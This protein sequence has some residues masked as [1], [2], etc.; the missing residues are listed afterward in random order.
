M[1]PSQAIGNVLAVHNDALTVLH[2]RESSDDLLGFWIAAIRSGSAVT[3]RRMRIETSL[4][5]MTCPSGRPSSRGPTPRR[6]WWL[7]YAGVGAD[8]RHL[9]TDDATRDDH[10]A[11]CAIP[12]ESPDAP[13][14]KLTRH[15]IHAALFPEVGSAPVR[16]GRFELLR[17][18]GQGG[19]GE[20]YVAYDDQLDREVALKLLLRERADDPSARERM[21]REAQVLARLSHPNVVQIHEAGIHDD[22]VYLVMELVDGVT[23]R[24]W[25]DDTPEGSAV[26]P[27]AE[28]LP[29]MIAAGQ[30]LA[31]AHAAGL[32][33]RDFKPDNV[34]VGHDGRVRVLD[35]GLARPGAEQDEGD[36]S[37]LAISA[38]D[39]TTSGSGS[40]AGR[41]YGS[42]SRRG[43]AQLTKPGRV[44]G[45]LAYMSPEQ[46]AARPLDART[47]QFSFC[48][49]LYEALY[50][51]RPF[52]G[53]TFAAHLMAVTHGILE[54]PEGRA[55]IP[56]W[57]RALVLRGLA[58][59]PDDRHPDMEALLRQLQRPRGRMG[60]MGLAAGVLVLGGAGLAMAL[61]PPHIP[62]AQADAELGERW[63]DQARERVRSAFVAAEPSYGAD[64]AER[65][66]AALDGR[67]DAWRAEQRD[68]CEDTRVRQ[69]HPLSILA[70]RTACIERSTADL[71]ALLHA[72]AEADA[73]IVENGLD[74]IAALPQPVRC[75]DLNALGPDA[76]D[77]PDPVRAVRETL[78]AIRVAR[79]AGNEDEAIAAADDALMRA[80]TTGYGPV[81]A[82]ALLEAARARLRGPRQEDK[83]PA[84]DLAWQA[85]DLAERHEHRELLFEIWIEL[86][87][88]DQ[89]RG[90]SERA[91]LW[92]RRAEV[93]LERSP[94]EPQ[95]RLELFFRRGDAEL[96][97]GDLAESQRWIRRG[98][99]YAE[100]QPGLELERAQLYEALGNTL[101]RTDRPAASLEAY[102]R[103]EALW[104]E[105]LGPRHPY[106]ARHDY[107]VGLLLTELGQVDAARERLDRARTRWTELFGPETM[108]TGRVELALAQLD[109]MTGALD[110]ALAHAQ[111]GQ[112]VLASTRDARDP[113]QIEALQ[114]LGL[115]QFRRGEL[116]GAYDTWQQALER[117]EASRSPEDSEALLTRAN[118]AETLLEQGEHGRA[119]EA[120]AALLLAVEPRA[121]QEPVMLM[122][123]LKGLGL[124]E[125]GAERPSEAT[126]R[127]SAAL[128]LLDLHGG[129]PLER[130]DL[131]W[132][133]ARA[134]R[135][136]AEP[137]GAVRDRAEGAA[138]LYAEHGQAE[139]ADDIRTWL[140]AFDR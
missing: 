3:T 71:R 40:G 43:I 6:P 121:D 91:R 76:P 102:D 70:R 39:P 27:R 98:L 10:R 92:A 129:H 36:G 16:V 56:R 139:R 18:L 44:V 82:E 57:L 1:H 120:Y 32:T 51:V 85:L 125:L 34:S 127:L 86:L 49:T 23:L 13:G 50:G 135:G 4:C 136:A 8:A 72:L 60:A 63:D 79:L 124:T 62:C 99:D 22:Q 21:L 95:R 30:G 80:E 105:H 89:R 104:R 84:V 133:L 94:S 108:L 106:L 137:S 113:L 25:L 33:H 45:T 119:R 100:G 83:D 103:A 11:Q 5:T 97:A 26:R 29:V 14:A 130:A 46:L 67:V 35:F 64:S 81:H 59:E 69:T 117:I 112:E 138:E 78:A 115:V 7:A 87:T 66:I 53:R 68:A 107:N 126:K 61:R 96:R 75:Q 17:R 111:R 88:E 24:Q 15:S 74:M 109:Q 38:D 47:D 122:L 12:S 52:A 41:S 37:S 132:A 90:R 20:V 116:Q 55:S 110:E 128:A 101:R 28:V 54:E 134:E 118:L 123:V 58:V 31:A 93:S 73:G 77:D 131:L 2:T 9:G 140:D 65:V 42:G 48:V 19:M 114:V